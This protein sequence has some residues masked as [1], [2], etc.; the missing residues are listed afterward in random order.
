[1]ER[2]NGTQGNGC[3]SIFDERN[4]KIITKTNCLCWC[5]KMG[6]LKKFTN[7]L[8]A[9]EATVNLKFGSYCVA[10]GE[11][12]SGS[13]SVC[14]GED[15]DITEVRCELQCVEQARVIRQVYDS[16]LRRTL[17]KE[18]EDCAVLFSAKPVLTGPTRMARGETRDFP[19]SINLPATG[20]P[21]Y[22]S[23]D[24][25]VT[26]TIKGVVAVNDRPDVVSKTC[27]I[28]VIASSA[29]PVIREKEIL[30][31]I[32]MIPCKYC[33]GLMEQTVTVCPNC[34]AKRTV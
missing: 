9:P 7:R 34:G 12:L 5:S 15:F 18:V 33:S 20:C 1:M 21:T 2:K 24:R 28:Q 30:R 32:V 3:N 11:N 8:T 22:K 14:S 17:P 27:E 31:E 25:K 6:F 4:S 19:L 23:I 29:Q 26:W 13:L 16:E 10:L